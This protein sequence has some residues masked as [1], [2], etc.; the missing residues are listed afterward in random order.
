MKLFPLYDSSSSSNS[1]S[2]TRSAD[3]S[4]ITESSFSS[5][6]GG[7]EDDDSSS[8]TAGATDETGSFPPGKA[9]SQAAAAP[10]IMSGGTAAAGSPRTVRFDL[11]GGAEGPGSDPALLKKLTQAQADLAGERALRR[12]KEKTVVKL[13]KE[14]NRRISDGEKKDH[15]IREVREGTKGDERV[16]CESC[17]D[18]SPP[19]AHLVLS[20]LI[21]S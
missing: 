17:R 5:G 15:R 16:R 21:F 19:S 1:S 7:H 20:L 14:L 3:M 9:K 13:A 18:T 12:R 2:P 10:N 6:I 8:T 11:G 4:G